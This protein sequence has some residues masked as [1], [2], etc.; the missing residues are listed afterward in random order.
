MTTPLELKIPGIYNIFSINCQLTD[1]H[2]QHEDYCE[3]KIKIIINTKPEPTNITANY[4]KRQGWPLNITPQVVE[5]LLPEPFLNWLNYM[6]LEERRVG[7]LFP[8]IVKFSFAPHASVY[9]DY[10]WDKKWFGRENSDLPE[11]DSE[12]GKTKNTKK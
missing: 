8:A 2:P 10:G 6:R 11:K 1:T 3:R 12:R 9:L 4:L 7:V 5:K